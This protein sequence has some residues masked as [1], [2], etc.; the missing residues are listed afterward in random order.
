MGLKDYVLDTYLKNIIHEENENH[1]VRA[2]SGT[3]HVSAADFLRR[4][5]QDH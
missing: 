1:C 4:R 3:D 5:R 2:G